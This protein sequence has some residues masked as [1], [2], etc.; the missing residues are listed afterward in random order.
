MTKLLVRLFVKDHENI[1][2]SHVRKAYGILGS[3]VA[4]CCNLL[5]FVTKLCV[6]LFAHSVSVL[7]DAFNNL[8]DCVSNV[9]GF[10]GVRMAD[11]PADK[12]HPFGH[13]RMEYLVSLV[14]AFL[15]LE[16]GFSFLKE[17]VKKILDPQEMLFEWIALVVLLLSIGV[18]LWMA[19]FNRRL[20]GQIGSTIME[21]TATDAVGDALA[22]F[23]TLISLLVYHFFSV[24]IDGW[25]GTLVAVFILAAGVGIIKNASAPLLGGSVD[26]ALY[27]RIK[28]FVESYEGIR[29]THDL[30]VHNYGPTT[31][32]A[33]IHVEVAPDAEFVRL[34][35]LIDQ[36]ERDAHEKLGISL[37]IHM[38]P[39]S[40]HSKEYRLA[41]RRVET[42]L[43]NLDGAVQIHDFQL[44]HSGEEI[45][46][47]FDMVVPYAYADEKV[48]DLRSR[49]EQILWLE[50]RRYRCVINCDRDDLELPKAEKKGDRCENEGEA[51]R[52]V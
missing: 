24:N 45:H 38:D 35:E 47:L 31:S 4:M 37:V 27:E 49:L 21:A 1:K 34:H 2:D 43:H 36:I 32:M 3:C 28:E 23:A 10:V 20:G 6:G 15:V 9:I 22:T 33:S 39:A 16:V 30:I 13:G 5:L 12:A 52:K 40:P 19:Y 18:K 25:V 17:S 14:V 41:K 7:A 51:D 46:L 48:E 8:S 50:E 11:K 44:V 29:G 42:I 26:T